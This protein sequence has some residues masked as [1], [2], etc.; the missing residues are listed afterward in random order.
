MVNQRCE[1]LTSL[2]PYGPMYIPITANGEPFYSEGVAVCFYKTDGTKWVAN[3]QPGWTNFTEIIKLKKT[4]NVMV[5]ARGT[6]YIMNPD[7]VKPVD[8]FGVGYQSI[9]EAS[10]DRLVLQ[11]LIDLTIIEADGSH[12]SSE[13]ISWDGF[14]EVKVSNNFVS[15]LAYSPIH[16]GEHWFPFTFDLDTKKLTGGSYNVSYDS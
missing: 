7:D 14:S 8:V 5:I 13:R 11:D 1:I 16:S 15:G 3:F 9:F 6:C 4:E 2:P 10:A 12:W